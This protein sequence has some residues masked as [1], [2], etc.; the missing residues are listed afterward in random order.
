MYGIELYNEHRIYKSTSSISNDWKN[1]G[2]KFAYAYDS[3]LK[4]H[5]GK[6]KIIDQTR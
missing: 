5:D 2:E 1:T 6:V 4:Y 3:V